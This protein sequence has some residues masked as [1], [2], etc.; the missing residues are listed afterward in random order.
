MI[1]EKFKPS[2]DRTYIAFNKPYAV[3]CQFSQSEGNNKRTLAEFGFPK[4]VYSV[5]RL[6]Y[7]SEGLLLLTDDGRLNSKLLR[8]QAGH[9][10]TYFACV[11]NIP[12]FEQLR[13]LKNGVVIEG[14]RT[15]PAQANLLTEEPSLPLRAVPIRTRK[16]IPTSWIELSLTEGR[17]R[18]V[19][20]MTAAIGCPT[21]RLMR[22]AIGSLSLFDLGLAP[23]EW[24]ILNGNELSSLFSKQ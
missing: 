4:D 15:L 21:L 8:P 13:A 3:L 1:S 23:G 9:R 11:E 14:K 7:D 22:V 5:G 17:N 18:Q 16:Y 24:K 10:R 12:S 2:V 19:R 6:D 20:K